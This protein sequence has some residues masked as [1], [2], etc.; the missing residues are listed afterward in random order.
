MEGFQ[1]C[2]QPGAEVALVHFA[3][4]L[5]R[6]LQ[7]QLAQAKEAVGAAAQI[8]VGTGRQTQNRQRSTHR[9]RPFAGQRRQVAV[10]ARIGSQRQRFGHPQRLHQRA[11][12]QGFARSIALPPQHVRQ[13]G[14]QGIGP[15]GTDDGFQ[16]GAGRQAQGFALRNGP[17][18]G[19]LGRH[20][21]AYLVTAGQHQCG[22]GP[23]QQLAQRQHHYLLVLRVVGHIA[24][25]LQRV[26]YPGSEFCQAQTASSLGEIGKFGLGTHCETQRREQFGPG[27]IR[28][29]RIPLAAGLQ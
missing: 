27:R 3:S 9:Q 20:G 5:L 14:L 8:L 4:Q 21:Q 16:H 24:G 23:G 25:G 11:G 15:G 26:T 22:K 29:Q 18:T 6:L 13:R 19:R 7:T 2:V 10:D 1:H 17:G 28:L 12:Q